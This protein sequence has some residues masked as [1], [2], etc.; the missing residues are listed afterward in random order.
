MIKARIYLFIVIKVL[1]GFILTSN[2]VAL[3]FYSHLEAVY[4][5]FGDAYALY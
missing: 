3:L 5:L 1:T 4:A 2:T